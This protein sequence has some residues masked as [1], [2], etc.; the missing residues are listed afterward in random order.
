[1]TFKTCSRYVYGCT[2]I[3]HS[4][5]SRRVKKKRSRYSPGL[6]WPLESKLTKPEVNHSRF[7]CDWFPK[8]SHLTVGQ[9]MSPGATKFSRPILSR[10][11]GGDD[12]EVDV[13]RTGRREPLHDGT[14]DRSLFVVGNQGHLPKYDPS[15]IWMDYPAGQPSPLASSSGETKSSRPILSHPGLQRSSSLVWE[16]HP[17]E[18]NKVSPPAA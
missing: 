3:S 13:M 18:G 11:G 15:P 16:D 7:V 2:P 1:M 6:G 14:I 5:L 12:D 4:L 8:S 9:L 17:G 10:P